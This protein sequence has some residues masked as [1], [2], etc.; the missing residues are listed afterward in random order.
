NDDRVGGLENRLDAVE[1]P[2]RNLGEVRSAMVDERRIHGAQDTVRNRCW[3]RNLQEMTA[4][5]TRS[6]LGHVRISRGMAVISCRRRCRAETC[7]HE[8]RMSESVKPI[9]VG[10]RPRKNVGKSI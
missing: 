4:G 10:L 7:R 1:R 9:R 5:V 2:A 8:G 3:P 6:V